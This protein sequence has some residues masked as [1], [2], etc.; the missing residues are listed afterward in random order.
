MHVALLWALP[1]LQTILAVGSDWT[2]SNWATNVL[3]QVDWA[4]LWHGMHGFT[5]KIWVAEVLESQSKE[6]FFLYKGSRRFIGPPNHVNN[7]RLWYVT[8]LWTLDPSIKHFLGCGM[9][10]DRRLS[11]LVCNLEIMQVF[12]S[13]SKFEVDMQKLQ[14]VEWR[15][16]LSPK[17]SHG[18]NQLFFTIEPRKVFVS[19]INTQSNLIVTHLVFLVFIL[20]LET[21]P[22]TLHI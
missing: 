3:H 4:K 7:W 16:S 19:V 20:N 10:S 2:R 5:I 22:S 9:G 17:L 13:Y 8:L 1:I 11:Y 21:L 6:Y 14:K 15:V 18:P 12:V